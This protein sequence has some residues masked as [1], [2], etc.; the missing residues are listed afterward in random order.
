MQQCI[1]A[2]PKLHNLNS[3]NF[4]SLK[5]WVYHPTEEIEIETITTTTWKSDPDNIESE[6]FIKDQSL[7]NKYLQ[8]RREKVD[9]EIKK[10][11][12]ISY[13]LIEKI[14]SAAKDYV[15]NINLHRFNFSEAL[16]KTF[17]DGVKSDVAK[18]YWFNQFKNLF[19]YMY[20]NGINDQLTSEYRAKSE[21]ND[22]FDR[23]FNV[24]KSVICDGMD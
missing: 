15:D 1:A 8:E 13:D 14:H 19:E 7:R 12:D 17:E 23:Y 18:E 21:I 10:E 2:F 20:R 4:E 5:Y 24:L 6:Y 3:V 11:V 16:I 9:P 22:N